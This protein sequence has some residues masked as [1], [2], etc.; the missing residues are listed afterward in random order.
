MLSLFLSVALA[1]SPTAAQPQLPIQAR[2]TKIEYRVPMRDGK[3]LYVA[4]YA[5]KNMPGKHPILLERTPYRAGPYG[6]QAFRGRMPGSQKF[7]DA[8]Y[9]FA[10]E[11]VRGRYMSEGPWVELRPQL[12]FHIKPTDIDESTDAYDTIDYLVK[13]VPENNGRVGVLG[14]SYPGF[15]AAAAGINSHPALKALSPQAPSVENFI[16]DDAHHH[17]ALFLQDFVDFYYGFGAASPV[18]VQQMPRIPGPAAGGDSYK[19]YQSLEPLTKV[20]D[21][22]LKHRVRFWDDTLDHSSMDEYWQARSLYRFMNDVKCPTLVVG[23]WFDAED[24]YGTIATYHAM[25][26]LNPKTALYYAMG[27]WSHGGWA[28][29]AGD[30]FVKYTFGQ[31]TAEYFRDH[32]EFPFFDA[33]L[34]GNGNPKIPH[35][36]VFQMGDNSWRAMDAWPPKGL[37]HEDFYLADSHGITRDSSS[38]KGQDDYVSDPA[39][40]TPYQGGVLRGRTAS[41]MADDQRFA[42]SRP[43]VLTYR[44]G[45]LDHDMTIAGPVIVHLTASTTGTDADFVVKVIDVQPEDAPSDLAGAEL[46]V[47]GDIMRGKF[48]DSYQNPQAFDPGKPTAVEFSMPDTFF[49]FKKGHRIEVQVQS[50]WFPLVDINPNKF[51][52]IYHAVPEDFQKATVTIYHSAERPSFVRFGTL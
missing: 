22:F 20:D 40:P 8:G 35:V 1:Q 9:I 3:K 30:K 51:C 37:K 46:L 2:Y 14:I 45:L 32:I 41:Y 4:V 38:G 43:D 24:L 12:L 28:G 48:R 50:S 27:P 21:V 47:R 36:Q 34:R 42:A 16:G 44:S 25:Q 7:Q 11:D 31:R 18:P 23:G 5:P 39:S 17:G 19:F 33:C 13:N 29:G 10:F 49:T 6:P 15:Y 26:T 52:D